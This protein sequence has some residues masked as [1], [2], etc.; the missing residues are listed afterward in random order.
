MN[1]ASPAFW[2]SFIKS[3]SALRK[4]FLKSRIRLDYPL[5]LLMESTNKCNMRCVFCP[6]E[7]S[8]RKTG[9]MSLDTVKNI[10]DD[11]LRHGRRSIIGFQKDGEPLLHK[12]IEEIIAYVKK[13]N[14]ATL[15]HMAT[16]GILLDEG[17]AEKII[18]SGLDDMLI[19]LDASS[20][21]TYRKVKGVDTFEKVEENVRNFFKIRKAMKSRRPYVRVKIINMRGTE[22]EVPEFKK[23][24]SGIADSIEVKDYVKWG[25]VEDNTPA[26][27]KNKRRHACPT[28]WYLAAIN[29]DGRVSVCCGDYGCSIPLGNINEKPLYEIW[30]GDILRSAR[31]SHLSGKFEDLEVC[32]SCNFWLLEEDIADWLKKKFRH[33]QNA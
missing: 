7:S 26:D 29:W 23:R 28:L 19:S 14:A 20:P 22:K 1:Y 2:A 10:I 12:G 17:R 27:F 25:D 11:S 9:F 24:W 15:L 30:N 18:N 6:R 21:D 33:Q 16:N 5:F 8:S 32:K 4:I 3:R 31:K 13:A